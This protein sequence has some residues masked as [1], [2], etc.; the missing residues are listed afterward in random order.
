M[1][2]ESRIRQEL[3]QPKSSSELTLINGMTD[4]AQK[5]KDLNEAVV[6]DINKLNQNTKKLLCEHLERVEAQNKTYHEQLE[7]TSLTLQHLLNALLIDP[8]EYPVES[9]Q[10]WKACKQ[11]SAN[12]LEIRMGH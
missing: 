10:A 1:D 6:E 5:F 4:L 12:Y 7:I 3:L 11:S 2:L 8:E 9:E